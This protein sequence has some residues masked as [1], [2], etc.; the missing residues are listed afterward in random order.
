M[1]RFTGLLK[2]FRPARDV[3]ACLDVQEGRPLCA[4][5]D[6]DIYD[7][8][9]GAPWPRAVYGSRP[10]VW[11][12]DPLQRSFCVVVIPD[13]RSIVLT[14]NF[15]GECTSRVLDGR[16]LKTKGV[17]LSHPGDIA[18]GLDRFF[19][20]EK[21]VKDPFDPNIYVR[22]FRFRS[23]SKTE[24]VFEE[25]WTISLTAHLGNLEIWHSV[26]LT[27]ALGGKQLIVANKGM[28]SSQY[29]SAWNPETGDFNGILL[30]DPAESRD[31]LFKDVI[32]IDCRVFVISSVSNRFGDHL[33][34]SVLEWRDP[35]A[36]ATLVYSLEM[37][38]KLCDKLFATYMPLSDNAHES[39]NWTKNGII[40]I[41][42]KDS[43][44]MYEFSYHPNEVGQMLIF[45]GIIN[46]PAL[47]K[48]PLGIL[49]HENLIMV[50]NTGI[51][52]SDAWIP[53]AWIPGVYSI[54]AA[55]PRPPALASFAAR[56]GG[57]RPQFAAR[58]GGALIQFEE[59]E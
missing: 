30:D 34:I 52:K 55:A 18:S 22:A 17:A 49:Y 37:P 56:C 29:V 35:A 50:L 57:A 48:I 27:V 44:R 53:D 15:L 59:L 20:V 4:T 12:Y 7:A 45:E 23:I 42:D 38:Y 3:L 28:G 40:L 24:I 58:R 8:I 14:I 25:I 31:L 1:N 9:C 39:Q 11:V 26:F 36:Q 46:N 32:A 16:A 47:I 21:F 2:I 43:N 19:V 5:G 13:G 10:H 6:R 54:S 51:G 41:A 33:R